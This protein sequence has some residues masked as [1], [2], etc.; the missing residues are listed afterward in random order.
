MKIETEDEV[1]I[2]R[3]DVEESEVGGGSISSKNAGQD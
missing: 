2:G 3:S 1:E